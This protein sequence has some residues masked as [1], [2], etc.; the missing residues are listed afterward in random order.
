MLD[1][2]QFH[3]P[4]PEHPQLNGGINKIPASHKIG[5]KLNQQV[6]RLAVV[7]NNIEEIELDGILTRTDIR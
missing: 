2:M 1:N 5:Y 4:A 7:R 6:Q 3:S